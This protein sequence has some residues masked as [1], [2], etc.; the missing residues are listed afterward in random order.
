VRHLLSTGRTRIGHVTG[1]P[2]FAASRLR[3]EGAEQA[4]AAAGLELVAGGALYGEWTEEWGRQAADALLRAAPDLDAI[5]CGNDQIARGVADTVREAGKRGARGH[6][7]GR[8]RQLGGHSRGLPPAADHGGHEP[9][10]AR[11]DGGRGTAERHRGPAECGV[12]RL[13]CTLVLR[14]SSRPRQGQPVT[15]I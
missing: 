7:A 11:P 15:T 3:A 4:L 13:P 8:L 9:A 12:R 2:S 1:P 6:R 10:R 14:E 5:F